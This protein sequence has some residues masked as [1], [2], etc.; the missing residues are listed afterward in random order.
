[1]KEL[2]DAIFAVEPFIDSNGI[3]RHARSLQDEALGE[4]DREPLFTRSANQVDGYHLSI[5][6]KHK[7]GRDSRKRL[8]RNCFPTK[9]TK[10]RSQVGKGR[11]E[12]ALIPMKL[13]FLFEKPAH[14]GIQGQGGWVDGMQHVEAVTGTGDG[15]IED[16]RPFQEATR[17]HWALLVDGK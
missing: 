16:I 15:H 11:G 2:D 7:V 14:E 8:F 5:A 13:R 9:R 12:C 1:M 3:E 17:A 4:L 10:S 6:D